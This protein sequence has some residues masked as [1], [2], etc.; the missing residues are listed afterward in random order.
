MTYIR[1]ETRLTKFIKA[2]VKKLEAKTNIDKYRVAANITEYH[3][4]SKLIFLR[5][6][7]QNFMKKR[8]LFHVKMSKINMFKWTCGLFGH[9][10]RVAALSTLYLTVSGIIIPSL[11]SIGQL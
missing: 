1:Y 6:I 5:L 4:A 7:I 2:K 8:R 11:K 3:I 10:Y 9:N